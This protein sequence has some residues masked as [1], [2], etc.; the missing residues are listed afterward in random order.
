MPIID[1]SEEQESPEAGPSRLDYA[2][3]SRAAR[4]ARRPRRQPS[5]EGEVELVSNIS[6]QHARRNP[7]RQ[8][9]VDAGQQEQEGS[10]AERARRRRLSEPRSLSLHLPSRPDHVF[11]NL[12]DEPE[13]SAANAP[14]WTATDDDDDSYWGNLGRITRGTG[15]QCPNHSSSY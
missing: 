8:A 13:N 3:D 6:R 1:L 15:S 10:R 4:Q 14:V 11:V 2:S 12:A 9:Q 5:S 7:R